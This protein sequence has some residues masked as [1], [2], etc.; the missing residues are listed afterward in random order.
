MLIVNYFFPLA[1]NNAH[2]HGHDLKQFKTGV[3]LN[4]RKNFFSQR[5]VNDWINCH[6]MFSRGTYKL[7]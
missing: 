2:L 5:V 1:I 4:L 3:N 7:N 6:L